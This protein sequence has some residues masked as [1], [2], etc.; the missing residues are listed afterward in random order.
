M[1]VLIDDGDGD[2]GQL[3]GAEQHML[4][5]RTLPGAGDRDERIYLGE[6][7]DR[8]KAQMGADCNGIRVVAVDSTGH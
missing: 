2:A 5:G 4:D 3:A 6:R 7:G 1:A 8:G